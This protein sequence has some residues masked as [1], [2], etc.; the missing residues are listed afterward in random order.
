MLLL[1]YLFLLFYPIIYP[2]FIPHHDG[3]LDGL[4]EFGIL[5]CVAQGGGSFK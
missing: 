1:N 2:V 4:G 3:L 5:T